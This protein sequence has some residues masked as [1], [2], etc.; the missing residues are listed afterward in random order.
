MNIN[1]NKI[2]GSIKDNFYRFVYSPPSFKRLGDVEEYCSFYVDWITSLHDDSII[3]SPEALYAANLFINHGNMIPFYF[4]KRNLAPVM[5]MRANI[6]KNFLKASGVEINFDFKTKWKEKIKIGI[7]SN[8]FRDSSETRITIPYTHLNKNKYEV[9]GYIFHSGESAFEKYYGSRLSSVTLL[10]PD[11]FEA[12]KLIRS[13]NLDIALIGN[14]TTANCQGITLL[15]ACKLAKIQGTN[16]ASPVSTGLSSMDFYIS[17]KLSEISETSNAHSQYTEELILLDGVG[18]CFDNESAPPDLN[19]IYSREA[20]NIKQNEVVFTSGAN[21]YKIIP[22]LMDCWSQILSLSPHSILLLYPFGTTWCDS[23][24]KKEFVLIFNSYLKKY[25]V[26]GSRLI[27]LNALPNR[28]HVRNILNITDI[29]LE[30]FPYQGSNSTSDAVAACRPIVS[31]TGETVRSRQGMAMISDMG[32]KYNKT[33]QEYINE[34]VAL[35][36]DKELRYSR[37]EEMEKLNKNNINC[38]NWLN[39]NHYAGLLDKVL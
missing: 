3:G 4:S 39:P 21:Y 1:I 9:H 18:F 16:F 24:P 23:Y 22:E 26:E 32:L 30:S 34:A 5:K 19:L 31:I 17:G 6:I 33:K 35:A 8:M 28:S 36:S 2:P 10:P 13:H 29:Y 11:I 14:N 37:Y 38:I 12:L 15:A 25:G 27:T 7:F 20:F